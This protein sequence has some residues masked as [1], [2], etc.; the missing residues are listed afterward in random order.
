MPNRTSERSALIEHSGVGGSACEGTLYPIGCPASDRS[1]EASRPFRDP[2]LE[3]FAKRVAH[4]VG[5]RRELECTRV[6][7]SPNGPRFL[8]CCRSPHSMTCFFALMRLE[9]KR[10]RFSPSSCEVV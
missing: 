7:M 4:E 2:L 3:G 9:N 6:I 10:K 1:D 5:G 8:V